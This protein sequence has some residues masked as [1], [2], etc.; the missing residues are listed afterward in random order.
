MNHY[1]LSVFTDEDQATFPDFDY[2]TNQKLCIIYCSPKEVANF[3]VYLD[4]MI[5]ALI[6]FLF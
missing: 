4:T 5:Y 1:F 3:N 6:Q 2:F